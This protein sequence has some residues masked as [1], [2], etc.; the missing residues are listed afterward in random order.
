MDELTRVIA[1]ALGCEDR[2]DAKGDYYCREHGEY[3]DHNG[4]CPEATRIA[5]ALAPLIEARE[6]EA[7][8]DLAKPG[9]PS[10][11][12]EAYYYG[13]DRTGVGIIDD[14][15]SAVAHAGKAFHGTENWTEFWY[16]RGDFLPHGGDTPVQ[17]IQNAADAAA[18]KV[19][20]V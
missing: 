16:G 5:A 14:I 6:R 1:E 19:R 3:L 9:D 4:R 11:R 17:A 7:R 20:N 8:A 12:M 15:L 13:F 10:A 2:S 18:E